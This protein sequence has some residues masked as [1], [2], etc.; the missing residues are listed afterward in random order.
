MLTTH[1]NF[2]S[3]ESNILIT[4]DGGISWESQL[5]T[6]DILNSIFFTDSQNGW[7]VGGTWDYKSNSRNSILY[8]TTDG[9]NT[10]T[11]NNEMSGKSGSYNNLFF[12]DENIGWIIYKNRYYLDECDIYKTTN[13]GLDWNLV[14]DSVINGSSFQFVDQNIGYIVGLFGDICKTSDG[15]NSWL[16]I[17]KGTRE[18]LSSIFFIDSINGWVVGDNST[19]LLTNNGGFDWNEQKMEY[20]GLLQSVFFINKDFGW[21][22]VK[23]YNNYNYYYAF[24]KTN[25][26]GSDWKEISVKPS[27]TS[28]VF[29]D[30]L[31]G[32]A[33][34]EKGAII[35]TSDGGLNWIEQESGALNNLNDIKLFDSNTG[36]IVGDSGIILT[37]SNGGN[38]WIKRISNTNGNLNSVCFIDKNNGWIC[39]ADGLIL[40][41]VDGG[42]NWVLQNTDITNNLNVIIF[43]NENLG[44]LLSS[45]IIYITNDGGKTWSG[46]NSMVVIDTN[47]AWVAGSR[48]TILHTSNGGITWVEDTPKQNEISK[49]VINAYPNP[50]YDFITLDI[51]GNDKPETIIIY[52]LFGRTVLTKQTEFLETGKSYDLRLTTDD[53]PQGVYFVRMQGMPGARTIIKINN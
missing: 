18:N 16:D 17:S 6:T 50:F 7:V 34:G 22:L 25:N 1:S 36:W 46:L 21:I 42:E 51:I 52:D 48:G 33:V 4:T 9:G 35:K 40:K 10:W 53:L 12:I 30:S 13:K 2:I 26:G 44:W 28:F 29:I 20:Y 5:N 37:T 11:V 15:G 45:S 47:N 43:K 31:F 49:L 3:Y 23:D 38:D 32:I 14:Q 19:F 41:T 8:Y 27:I 39:G 24:L